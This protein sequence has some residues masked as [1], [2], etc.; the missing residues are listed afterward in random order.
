MIVQHTPLK[1]PPYRPVDWVDSSERA[2]WALE[3]QEHLFNLFV[4]GLEFT[5]PPRKRAWTREEARESLLANKQVLDQMLSLAGAP[6]ELWE[7]VSIP[8]PP[9]LFDDPPEIACGWPSPFRELPAAG[10]S[11]REQFKWLGYVEGQLD[12][13]AGMLFMAYPEGNKEH[14]KA[15]WAVIRLSVLFGKLRLALLLPPIRQ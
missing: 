1:W 6:L 14:R 4:V 3:F 8:L 2:V 10:W 15:R 7:P 12:Y 13:L 9:P 11:T 5:K